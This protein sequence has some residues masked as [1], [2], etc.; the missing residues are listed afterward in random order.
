MPQ[1]GAGRT[2]GGAPRRHGGVS[3]SDGRRAAAGTGR[4]ASRETV[5]SGCHLR[6]HYYCVEYQSF[7]SLSHFATSL[8]LL[9]D[10]ATT[11]AC[12]SKYECF[13]HFPSSLS[14]C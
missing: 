13:R 9:D 7:G 5:S 4:G 14:S 1:D 10:D 2:G 12:S 6:Q 11:A 3:G 8:P